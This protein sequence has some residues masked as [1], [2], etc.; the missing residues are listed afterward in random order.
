MFRN[1]AL[2]GHHGFA[3]LRF[4]AGLEYG[5]DEGYGGGAHDL[6]E[7]VS[8]EDHRAYL[9]FGSL[10][11]GRRGLLLGLHQAEPLPIELISD[12]PERFQTNGDALVLALPRLG[13]VSMEGDGLA[14][15]VRVGGPLGPGRLL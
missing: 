15:H 2:M 3:P 10:H 7:P 1:P 4:P 13:A 14:S 11:V 8:F 9:A 12:G 5:N 6:L